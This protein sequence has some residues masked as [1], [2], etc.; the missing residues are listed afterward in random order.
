[1]PEPMS[2]RMSEY[3]S[4]KMPHGR[5]NRMLDGMSEY[6][7]DNMSAGGDVEDFLVF[8]VGQFAFFHP[9]RTVWYLRC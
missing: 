1:M 7:P 3:M 2:D 8:S 4:D 6:M 9:T 5:P